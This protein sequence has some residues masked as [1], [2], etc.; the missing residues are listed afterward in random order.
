MGLIYNS[1]GTFKN[2]MIC[3]PL[4]RDICIPQLKSKCSL[5]QYTF[6]KRLLLSFMNV[7]CE[8]P[9]WH[10]FFLHPKEKPGWAGCVESGPCRATVYGQKKND[11]NAGGKKSGG[12]GGTKE[13]DVPRHLY[14]FFCNWKWLKKKTENGVSLVNLA[15]TE[16]HALGFTLANSHSGILLWW[17]CKT[18]SNCGN[19]INSQLANRGLS[20]F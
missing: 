10:N 6:W 13:R 18:Q 14:I 19:R 12:G 11:W 8:D 2:P 15:G 5:F 3:G 17:K 16:N 4:L 9:I 20:K 1:C 7:Y